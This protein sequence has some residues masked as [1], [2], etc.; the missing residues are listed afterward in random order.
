MLTWNHKTIYWTEYL[1]EETFIRWIRHL[2]TLN[3]LLFRQ[4]AFCRRIFTWGGSGV[5]IIFPAH[6]CRW[7]CSITVLRGFCWRW[8]KIRCVRRICVLFVINNF[9][10]I[11]A[12]LP[13][14]EYISARSNYHRGRGISHDVKWPLQVVLNAHMLSITFPF[15]PQQ[16]QLLY[17][18]QTHRNACHC[19]IPTFH[20]AIIA[21][22]QRAK[23]TTMAANSMTI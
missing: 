23:T 15:S 9:N 13:R 7:R 3:W 6:I 8:H 10:S 2:L 18:I 5:N 1:P 19:G 16:Q 21:P 14:L 20:L 11:Q 4:A 17:N 22:V 12:P